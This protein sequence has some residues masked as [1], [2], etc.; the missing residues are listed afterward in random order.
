MRNDE[1]LERLRNYNF[2]QRIDLKNEYEDRLERFL[3]MVGR[4][5]KFQLENGNKINYPIIKKLLKKKNIDMKRDEHEYNKH[6]IQLFVE[7]NI[8]SLKWRILDDLNVIFKTE[9]IKFCFI[10]EK[11]NTTTK[12]LK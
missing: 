5:Q 4:S 8:D 10:K 6:K 1:I 2:F 3:I 11:N 7:K 9:K 12:K